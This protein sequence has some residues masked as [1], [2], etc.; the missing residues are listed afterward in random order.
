MLSKCA[1]P[2][3]FVRFRFLHEGRIFAVDPRPLLLATAAEP[4]DWVK[5][6]SGAVEFFWL[7][8]DCARDL[9]VCIQGG[10]VTTAKIPPGSVKSEMGQRS[11]NKLVHG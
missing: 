11:L 1:N 3:C 6:K 4:E 2:A 7:C 10:H 8:N 9:T 5:P